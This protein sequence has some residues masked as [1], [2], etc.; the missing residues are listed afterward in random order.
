MTDSV[1][2]ADFELDLAAYALRGPDGSVKLE[3]MPM[4]VL[5]LLVKR[6]GALVS[7]LEIRSA[8]WRDGVNV[9]YDSA[10][11]TVMRKV[12]HALADD[13]KSPRFVETVVGKGYRF[14][15][16]VTSVVSGSGR[17][18]DAAALRP[19]LPAA[20]EAYLRGRHAW[21]KRSE[22]DLRDAV[23][24]FQQSIDADP[25]YAPAYAGMADAY[26]QLG[27]GSYVRPEESFARARAAAVRGLQ[28]DATLA[29][30]H[31]ALGFVLMYYN[32]DFAAAEVE[33]RRALTADPTSALGHQWYA[34]LLTAM[35][36]PAGEAEREIASAKRLDPLSVAIHIDYA[37]ILHYYRRNAEALRSVQLALEM[38][39][40]FPLAYFWL[41]RIYTAESRYEEAESA[42]QKIGPLRTWTPAMAVCGY[43]YGKT[44]RVAEARAVLSE[45]DSL[46]ASG[47]YASAYAIAVVCA[48]LDDWETALARLEGAYR[49]RSHWLVWLKRDPRW[50]PIR[51][52][53]RFRDL[54]EK[55]GLP[56]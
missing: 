18:T 54:V 8:L 19:V 41:G 42:L 17:V 39:P 13:A 14:I 15:A 26:S 7:R 25:T 43:L 38:N 11:N 16:P 20:Y 52:D 30:A 34:Y 33:Y 37:Y 35:E 49:E 50:D 32:W 1:R 45:F 10:I 31:A 28:L 40:A 27:Y 21:N 51:C 12:R 9:E 2:F 4:E 3:R 6:A 23:R 5:I 55:V 22:A 24:F 46:S 29:E 36:R 56:A 53:R 48:G 44:G 47:R